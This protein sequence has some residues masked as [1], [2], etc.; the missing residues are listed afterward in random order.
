MIVMKFGG[1]S[2][3]NAEAM[4]RVSEIIRSRKNRSPI[5]V[6]SAVAGIT[7][8]LVSLA[9]TAGNRKSVSQ[10]NNSKYKIN[11]S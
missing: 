11:T 9:S 7:D 4:H 2:I 6:V 10:E 8:A 1:T 5:I 3:G